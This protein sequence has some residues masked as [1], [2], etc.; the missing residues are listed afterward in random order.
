MENIFLAL[1]I[2]ALNW[3][4]YFPTIFYDLAM[5]DFQ[6]WHKK[7][8]VGLQPL[9]KDGRLAIRTWPQLKG[10][11]DDRLYSGT[12]LGLNIRVEHCLTIA[13]HN[14]ICL[15]MF[16][17]FGH[18]RVA[19]AAAA[20]YAVNPINNQT[21]VWLNGRRYAVC[22]IAV[23][24]MVIFP[25]SSL[26][27]YPFT[28]LL[29]VTA[30][31]APVLLVGHSP[32]YLVL[33]PVGLLFGWRRIKAR[34]D[35]RSSVMADGDL[36]T[37]RWTRLIVVVKTFGFFFWKMIFPQVCAMQYMDRIKWGQTKE[38]NEDAYKIDRAFG[39]G[40]LAFAVLLYAASH[41]PAWLVPGLVFYLLA[42]LQWSA[43][44]PITQVLSD[45]YCSMPNVFMMFFVAYWA[46]KTGVLFVPIVAGLA[47]YYAVCLSVV[48]PMYENISK[49]YEYH[50]RHFPGLSW[51][52]HNLISDLMNEGQKDLAF[53]HAV[54]GLMHDRK[55]F[56][57]LMWGAILSVLK[58]RVKEAEDLLEEA[59]KNFYVNK[60]EEQRKEVE[61]LK[62][63]IGKLRP[64]Y[65][66]AERLTE[67]EK[68]LLL[69]RRGVRP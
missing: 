38:G 6:W 13:L 18:D 5:D 45:R 63:Q 15:L 31:F 24:L 21:S 56:R 54:Q 4:V 51:Y 35:A 46:S 27:L 29:Q 47:V 42:T 52:R 44:L 39:L 61:Y 23:L 22:I 8:Q 55:D 41:A 68:A 64:V 48:M 57:L 19:F 67:K 37:L 3:G 17:A 7:R 12:T 59:G 40:V 36:K 14:T 28:G 62:E 2:T 58:G 11:I 16:W 9:F 65:K 20:L 32:W 34:C 69:K 10:F 33:I 50:F 25:A 53:Y 43:V 49:W 1:C 66:K 30:F 26:V 60:E